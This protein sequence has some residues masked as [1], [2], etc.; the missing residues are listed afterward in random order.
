MKKLAEGARTRLRSD[1]GFSLMEVVVAIMILG[2]L[3]TASLGIYL[4]SINTATTQQRREIAITIA[5]QQME[6][7][8]SW[9]TE[10]NVGSGTSELYTGRSQVAVT[11]NWSTN[12]GVPGVDHTYPVWDQRATPPAEAIAIKSADPIEVTGTEYSVETLLGTCYQPKRTGG[13]CGRVT[14]FVGYPTSPSTALL[15]NYTPLTRVIVV[16]RWTSGSSCESGNCS[17]V[18]STLID[19]NADLNWNTHG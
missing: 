6:T 7:V 13:D 3:S 16:V 10:P 19:L 15:S 11:T 17:Y 8:N 9:S 2:V 18:T 12:A 14:G 4:A 5:N 1:D